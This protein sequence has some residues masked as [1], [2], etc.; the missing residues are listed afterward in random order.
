MRKYILVFLLSLVFTTIFAQ[1]SSS[2]LWQKCYG[3][4]QADFAQCISPTSDNGFIITGYTSSVNGDVT[5]SYGEAD[6]W[7]VKT[8]ESGQIQ[9]QK[10]YGGSDIDVAHGGIQTND[11]GYIFAGYTYST[12]GNVTGLHGAYDCWIIKT[13]DSG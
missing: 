3:G 7:V 10:S 11:G 6:F 2:M 1:V 13:D 4:A 12:N 5:V 8:T 9:W